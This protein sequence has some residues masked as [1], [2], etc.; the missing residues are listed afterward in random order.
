MTKCESRNRDS[1]RLQLSLSKNFKKFWLEIKWN[2]PFRLGPSGI[3]CPSGHFSRSD[4]NVPFLLIT[5][6]SP[7]PLFYIPS[8]STITKRAVAWVGF[9]AT[10]MYRSIGLVEFSEISNRNFCYGKAPINSYSYSTLTCLSGLHRRRCYFAIVPRPLRFGSR[11]PSEFFSPS[12]P[13][14]VTEMHRP[15]RPEKTPYRD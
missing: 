6:L 7:I 1:G 15:R 5:L 13:G 9:C 11:G 14:Y 12:C 3:F 2:G 4:G 8:T 10:G